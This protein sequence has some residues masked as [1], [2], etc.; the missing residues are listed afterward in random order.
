VCFNGD[1]TLDWQFWSLDFPMGHRGGGMKEAELNPAS[2]QCFDGLL[3]ALPA[4]AGTT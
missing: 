3:A 4:C 1:F 2:H